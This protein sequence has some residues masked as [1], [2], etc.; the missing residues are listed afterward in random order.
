MAGC[1]LEPRFTRRV[2]RRIIGIVDVPRR[3]FERAQRKGLLTVAARGGGIA[4]CGCC[5]CCGK[6]LMLRVVSNAGLVALKQLWK[7]FRYKSKSEDCIVP[8]IDSDSNRRDE[9]LLLHQIDSGH[10]ARRLC[11]SAVGLA[12]RSGFPTHRQLSR[13]PQSIG[14][15]LRAERVSLLRRVPQFEVVVP[16]VAA[17]EGFEFEECFDGW[18]QRFHRLLHLL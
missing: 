1:G 13:W 15:A 5:G 12:C 9:A 2:Q 16:D 17:L 18:R 6:D 8:Y 14:R 10:R 4:G 7:Q 11:F 3:Y